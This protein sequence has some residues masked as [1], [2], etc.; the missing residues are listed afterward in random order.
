MNIETIGPWTAFIV[1]VLVMLA[2]DLGLFHR[3]ARAVSYREAAMW[4]AIWVGLALACNLVLLFWRGQ[5]VALQFST[6]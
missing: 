3:Q 2:L 5:T 4:S 6:G 1:F